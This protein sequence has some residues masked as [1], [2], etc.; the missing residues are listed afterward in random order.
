MTIM[1]STLISTFIFSLLSRMVRDKKYRIISIF[2]ITLSIVTLIVFSGFRGGDIGDTGMY[3]HSYSLYADNPSIATFD[4]DPG[5]TILNLILI[6]ISSNPQTLLIATAIIVNLCNIFLFYKYDSYIELQVYLYITSGYFT[7]TMNG[8]RQCIA[9]AILFTCTYLIIK[10]KFKLYL[11]IVLLISTI[12]A[13]SLI[14]IPIYFIVRE[15]AWSKRVIVMIIIACVGVVFY[16]ILSPI[17]FKAIEN[18][19]Y[20]DYANFDGGGSSLMR[21]IVNMVSVILAYVK[22]DKL[23]E[24]WPKSNIFV[25]MAL[26]N[27]IFVAFG[28]F[29]WI[30]NRFTLYMQ[31]YNFILIPFIIRNCFKG[32]ERRLLYLGVLLCYF[33]FFYREQVI[34]MNMSY[35]SV[36]KVED[37]F[38]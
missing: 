27:V 3:M 32:K 12:H 14:M 26:I 25:N 8:M 13:S 16:N 34:G 36:L 30:F 9:A 1:N 19:Q 20:G 33:V 6:K 22:R 35:P 31:L 24:M 37:L 29:N 38:Y 21:T 7:I 18:T 17:L 15:E 2:W 5:F 10:G 23:K 28:M 11:L 4:R